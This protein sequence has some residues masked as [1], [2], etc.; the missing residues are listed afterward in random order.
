MLLTTGEPAEIIALGT[1]YPVLGM[2]EKASVDEPGEVE[3]YCA[4]QSKVVNFFSEDGMYTEVKVLD[5]VAE[6]E[7]ERKAVEVR[8]KRKLKQARHKAKRAAAKDIAE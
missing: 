4:S 8:E 2:Y 6:E 5:V 3:F 7:K 1:K